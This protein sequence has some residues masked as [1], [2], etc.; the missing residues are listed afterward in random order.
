M[1]VQNILHSFYVG[2]RTNERMSYEIYV[3]L[4]GKE[5]V[6][7]VL[8]CD[9]RQI[10]MHSRHI[11]TLAGSKYAVILNTGDNHRPSIFHNKHIKG[12]IVKKN[13]VAFMHIK[14]KILV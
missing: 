2:C 9:G 12:T 14:A 6:L 10:N 8:F 13:M 3:I 11:D 1:F 4:N 7:P 5:N